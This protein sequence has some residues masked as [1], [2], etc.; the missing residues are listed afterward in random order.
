MDDKLED[1]VRVCDNWLVEFINSNHAK[2]LT[3]EQ[4]W[5]ATYLIPSFVESMY[6]YYNLIPGEWNEEAFEKFCLYILPAKTSADKS[7][8]K[9]VTPIMFKFLAFLDEKNVIH[10][11]L[12]LMVKLRSIQEEIVENGTNPQFWEENE[13]IATEALLRGVNVADN[14]ELDSF[15]NFKVFQR[16]QKVL[17][18]MFELTNARIQGQESCICGSGKLYNDCCG[19]IKKRVYQL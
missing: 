13:S 1:I 8:F 7:F 18:E 9:D 14:S 6:K 11:T 16:N 12:E 10:N 15:L 4:A 3:A 17:E 2:L 5:G 19:T